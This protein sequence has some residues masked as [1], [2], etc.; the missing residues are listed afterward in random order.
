MS[1]LYKITN[2][3]KPDRIFGVFNYY[4]ICSNLEINPDPK[5]KGEMKTLKLSSG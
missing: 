3:D 5:A 1:L 2:L 4:F